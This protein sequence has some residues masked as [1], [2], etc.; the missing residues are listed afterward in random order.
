MRELA[1]HILDL[2][3]NSIEAGATRV[4]LEVIEDKDNDFLSIT[5]SDNGRGMHEDEIK[6]VVDPFVTSRT[7]RR[8]GLGLPLIDMYTQICGGRLDI[9]SEKGCG[10]TVEAVFKYSHIDRPPLGNMKDTIKTIII[11]NPYLDFQYS[12]RVQNRSFFVATAELRSILG[13]VPF[14]HPEVITWFDEYLKENLA[15]LHGGAGHENT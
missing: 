11:A 3:Q 6:A 15:C 12:N 1:L 13:G 2:V 10:T 4:S 7:T 14:T 5:V 8:V 9:K